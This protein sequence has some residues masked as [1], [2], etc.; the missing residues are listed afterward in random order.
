MSDHN[1]FQIGGYVQKNP[2]TWIANG[3]DAWGRG[4]SIGQIVQPPFDLAE[5]EVDVC[6]PAGH[7]FEFTSQ[8]LPANSV[9]K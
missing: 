6:W 5:A 1:P 9:R 4:Q 2:D 7:C 8:L 3:F